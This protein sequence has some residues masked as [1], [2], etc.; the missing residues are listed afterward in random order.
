MMF[1]Q[2]PCELLT[3]LK[4]AID[5]PPKAKHFSVKILVPLYLQFREEIREHRKESMGKY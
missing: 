2:H 1:W 5:Y 4:T 3:L